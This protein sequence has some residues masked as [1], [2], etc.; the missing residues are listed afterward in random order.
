M[1][2]AL[3][4]AIDSGFN[5]MGLN[6]I[7]AFVSL[8]NTASCRLLERLGFEREGIFREKHFFQGEYYDHYIYSLLK[9][10]WKKGG[11]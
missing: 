8:E 10:E 11:S 1:S 5:N 2:E 6:R 9:K 3:T 4:A 7:Q